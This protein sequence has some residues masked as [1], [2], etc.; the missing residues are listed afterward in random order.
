MRLK[1]Y[2]KYNNQLKKCVNGR[3]KS[4]NK[5]ERFLKIQ[6][7]NYCDSDYQSV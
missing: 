2:N 1:K 5:S 7:I 4:Y 6:Y 3:I